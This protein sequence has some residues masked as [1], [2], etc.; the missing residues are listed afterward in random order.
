MRYQKQIGEKMLRYFVEGD[1]FPTF[2]KFA[3]LMGVT[4]ADLDGWRK[5]SKHFR[6]VYGQCAEI[7]CDAVAEG[8]LHRRLD[9]SFSKFYLATQH[10]WGE[11]PKGDGEFVLRVTVG[12]GGKEDGATDHLGDRK[13]GKE[14]GE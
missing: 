5:T 1:G 10:G 14:K 8:A 13:T 6:E 12:N 4:P 2:V 3:K 9:P 11:G 7:L